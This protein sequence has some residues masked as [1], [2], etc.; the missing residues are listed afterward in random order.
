M[1]TSEQ[2]AQIQATISVLE[3]S[4]STSITNTTK[5]LDAS[6]FTTNTTENKYE[7][8]DHSGEKVDGF[9]KQGEYGPKKFIKP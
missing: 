5:P 9:R 8:K 4:N 2:M 1:I 7:L 3:T 6:L